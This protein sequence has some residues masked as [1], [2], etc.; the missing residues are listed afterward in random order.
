MNDM[1]TALAKAG[2]K[3][4][5]QNQRIWTYLKDFG[6][7]DVK[8]I[9]SVTKIGEA[10]VQ[11]TITDLVKRGMLDK[12]E[13]V[14]HRGVRM[15][16]QYGALGQQ[17]ELLP[18]PK[19]GAKKA[20]KK[21]TTPAA[22]GATTPQVMVNVT[23]NVPR[24]TAAVYEKHAKEYGVTVQDVFRLAMEAYATKMGLGV[25]LVDPMA[26]LRRKLAEGARA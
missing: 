7:G 10:T 8:K 21:A 14:D 26:A 3:L 15:R 9:A 12:I 24:V 19:K 5:A 23:M 1:S 22:L 11:A 6:P 20:V 18:P 4:P 13:R 25:P 17:F 2:V 16:N